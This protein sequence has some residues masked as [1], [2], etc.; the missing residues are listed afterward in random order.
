MLMPKDVHVVVPAELVVLTPSSASLRS[1][2]IFVT[3]VVPL[4]VTVCVVKYAFEV[5][6]AP[7]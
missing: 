1:A 3:V 4:I 5:P 6:P 2:M 7:D